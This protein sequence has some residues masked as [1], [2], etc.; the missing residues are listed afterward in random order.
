MRRLGYEEARG[1]LDKLWALKRSGQCPQEDGLGIGGHGGRTN[2]AQPG[3]IY[4]QQI[5]HGSRPLL[6][7][8][9]P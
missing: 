7:P 9:C 2:N 1:R 5:S 4:L 3:E 6:N 8:P